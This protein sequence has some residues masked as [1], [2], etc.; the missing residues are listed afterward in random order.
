MDECEWILHPYFQI[1]EEI[2]LYNR[3]EVEEY[4]ISK[5]NWFTKP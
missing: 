4:L 3:L 2:I 5:D 1:E